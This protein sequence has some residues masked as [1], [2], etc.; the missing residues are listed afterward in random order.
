MS[1]NSIRSCNEIPLIQIYV[2]HKISSTPLS[3][4][5]FKLERCCNSCSCFSESSR[6]V[7]DV[8]GGRYWLF[9][10]SL[11][12]TMLYCQVLRVLFGA[13]EQVLLWCWDSWEA[14]GGS[15]VGGRPTSPFSPLRGEPLGS[16][17]C[18]EDGKSSVLWCKLYQGKDT[19]N[20]Y[21]V[22]DVYLILFRDLKA[23]SKLVRLGLHVKKAERQNLTVPKVFQRY[24]NL[25]SYVII[26]LCPDLSDIKIL[27]Y[28][29]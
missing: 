15:G 2:K 17:C 9:P 18:W 13:G 8:E 3:S 29:G 11:M 12:E 6:W 10:Q 21:G 1:L 24:K 25:I 27:W 20:I 7:E 26:W 5:S 28:M 19:L 23:V 16:G 4:C 14:C 22:S